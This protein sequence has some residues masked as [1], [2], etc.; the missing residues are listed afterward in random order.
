[1]SGSDIPPELINAYR[2][3]NYRVFGQ[4]PF[5]LNIGKP[6]QPLQILYDEHGCQSAAFITAWNPFSKATDNA[7]NSRL[8]ALLEIE[9][10]GVSTTLIA[11]IGED[12]SGRWPGE[13]STLALGVSLADAKSIGIRFK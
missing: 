3:T 2:A 7:E 11:G 12:S 4:S 6:S 9:L 10:S 13:E 8:Q 5:V 1:M